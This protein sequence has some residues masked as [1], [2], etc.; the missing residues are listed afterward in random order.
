MCLPIRH[1][2]QDL[3]N[4]MTI[5]HS[6]AVSLVVLI[7]LIGCSPSAPSQPGEPGAM[8]GVDASSPPRASTPASTPADEAA[9]FGV[10]SYREMWRVYAA[11]GTTS[12]WRAPDLSLYATGT[13]LSTL[14]RALFGNHERGLVTR[15]EPRVAPSAMSVEPA[16]DPV[17]VTIADCGDSSG[18]TKHHADTGQAVEDEPGGRRRIDAVAERQADGSWK[19]SGFAVQAVGTC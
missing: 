5:F 18:W 7:T 6:T 13:A 1:L 14:T 8:A 12:D 15:G 19:V 10:E 2:D 17:K 16:H 3:G 4:D 11:A 9:R